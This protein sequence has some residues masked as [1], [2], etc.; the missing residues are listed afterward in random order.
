MT[1]NKQPRAPRARSASSKPAPQARRLVSAADFVREDDSDARAFACAR[2]RSREE[3][4]KAPLRERLV[5]AAIDEVEEVGFERFS[6]RRVAAA[7][8]CSCAAPYKHFKNKREFFEAI[9]D[10]ITDVWLERQE[11]TKRRCRGAS[12]RTLLVELAV[13]YV[14]FMV[15]N[16]RYRAI[17]MIKDQTFDSDYLDV[18]AKISD[19]SKEVILQ[20]CHENGVERRDAVIK[21]YVVRSLIYGASLMFG[22]RELPYG[23]VAM[24]WVRATIDREFDLPTDFAIGDVG[25]LDSEELD[26]LSDQIAANLDVDADKKSR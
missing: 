8:G 16:P 5:L 19:F 26:A 24:R 9:L 11:K 18:K 14:R 1:T 10:H 22:N 4:A 3:L 20:Y 15:E 7:C 23:D 21:M 2:K 17:L 12:L 6:V 13:E 25:K